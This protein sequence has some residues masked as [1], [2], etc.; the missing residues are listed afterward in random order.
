LGFLNIVKS[1]G[2]IHSMSNV[3]PA[4]TPLTN[5]SLIGQLQQGVPEAWRQM[6]DAY[7]LTILRWVRNQCHQRGLHDT[8]IHEDVAQLILMNIPRIMRSYSRQA[9]IRYRAYL[10]QVIANAIKDAIRRET[11]HPTQS[12]SF[13]ENEEAQQD[14]HQKMETYYDFELL[15]QAIARLKWR[16]ARNGQANPQR[17]KAF[18]LS[19]PVAYFGGLQKASEEVAAELEVDVNFVYRAKAD[20]AQQL[21]QELENLDHPDNPL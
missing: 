2:K 7:A 12:M 18:E 20:L 1:R 17:W 21:K 14:L 11:R 3:I 9:H 10:K 4:E 5:W 8:H 15:Q 16:L 6:A 13:L 19:M